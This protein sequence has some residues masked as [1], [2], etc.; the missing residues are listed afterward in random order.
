MKLITQEMTDAIET[1]MYVNHLNRKEF[2]KKIGV[3]KGT[4]SMWLSHSSKSIKWENWEKLSLLIEA[5]MRK[6]QI[7]RS[8][9]EAVIIMSEFFAKKNERLKR[10]LKNKIDK[11]SE[12]EVQEVCAFFEKRGNAIFR[13]GSD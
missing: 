3:N 4:L 5:D 2:A 7:S 11:L 12:K 1:Y 10:K 8:F 13:G 6:E 9:D